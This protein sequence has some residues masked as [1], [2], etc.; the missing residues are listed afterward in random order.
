[1]ISSNV[2]HRKFSSQYQ[3]IFFLLNM[4][5]SPLHSY[6]TY[7]LLLSEIVLLLWELDFWNFFIW[8]L[9]KKYHTGRSLLRLSK[10]DLARL[11]LDYQGKLNYVLQSLKDD[12]GQMKSLKFWN[13]NWRLVKTLQIIWQNKQKLWNVN[14]MKMN[15]TQ[16]GNQ[17]FPALMIAAFLKALFWNCFRKLMYTLTQQ[18]FRIAV[19][20]NL[21]IALLKK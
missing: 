21:E 8:K 5:F 17:A 13:L 6:R 15:I 7:V 3:L 9:V 18:T 4:H 14:V 11:V 12:V 1:M 19:T 2:T 20:L 16:G 10:N